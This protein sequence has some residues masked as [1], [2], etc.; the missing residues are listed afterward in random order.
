MICWRHCRTKTLAG[1]LL[2]LRGIPAWA[3]TFELSFSPWPLF[4]S[5]PE[6]QFRAKPPEIELT[7]SHQPLETLRALSYA[8]P[9]GVA[10]YSVRA[11]GA[12]DM[13]WGVALQRV[14]ESLAVIDPALV[15]A[16]LMRA[17]GRSPFVRFLRGLRDLSTVAGVGTTALNNLDYRFRLIAPAVALLAGLYA[18]RLR[19]AETP[20][21]VAMGGLWL[22]QDE[23]LR[24]GAG[25]CASRLI[26]ARWDGKTERFAQTSE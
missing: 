14:E 9:K 8:T 5:P 3:Q 19:T 12:A 22:R 25:Q 10:L 17:R 21:S 13:T 6:V 4:S 18:D 16:T 23:S 7:V 1:M 2:L 26:L 15:D 11:C 20:P 24:L